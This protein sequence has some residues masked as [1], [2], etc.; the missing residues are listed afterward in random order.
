MKF[1]ST[2]GTCRKVFDKDSLGNPYTTQA[3]ADQALAM[4]RGRVHSKAIKTYMGGPKPVLALAGGEAAG[5]GHRNGRKGKLTQEQSDALVSF[6]R[7]RRDQFNSKT[8]C[9]TAALADV[10]VDKL[11]KNNSVAVCRYF[12][13]ADGKPSE[14]QRLVSRQQKVH[15]VHKKHKEHAVLAAIEPAQPVVG[16][17]PSFVKHCPSC[18]VVLDGAEEIFELLQDSPEVVHLALAA[19]RKMMARKLQQNITTHEER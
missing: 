12:N 6:I 5:N 8:A 15:K 17:R 19:A 10:G 18:G 11:I 1:T 16:R 4:H 7:T 13:K 3:R 2:C 14:Y 9:F